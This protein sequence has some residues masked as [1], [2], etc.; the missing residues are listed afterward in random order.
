VFHD[1][2]L[3]RGLPS[4]PGNMLQ[5]PKG[6]VTMAAPVFSANLKLYKTRILFKLFTKLECFL[7]LVLDGAGFRHDC[8]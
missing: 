4:K 6:K 1:T 7:L 3:Q 2:G 8:P 5:H